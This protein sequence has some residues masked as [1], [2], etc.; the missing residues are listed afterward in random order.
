MGQTQTYERAGKT[1][2]EAIQKALAEF[3]VAREETDITILDTGSKGILGIGQKPAKIK[4]TVKFI[5]EVRVKGYINEIAEAMGV[6]VLV[7]VDFDEEK[8]QLRVD[9]VGENLGLFIGKRGQ[10]LDALQYL[11]NLFINKGDSDYI[12]VILDAEN[13]RERRRETLESLANSIARKVKQT[14]KNVVLEPMSANERRI[15]HSALQNDKFVTTFSEGVE[16]FRNVV[17]APKKSSQGSYAKKPY[18]PRP[19]DKD[20]AKE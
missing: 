6:E 1:V 4:I 17:I 18:R 9:I 14:R 7:K 2:D 10:T 11:L 20:T 8:S 12:S 3:K 16:P 19:A 5:P 15:V 13:Y